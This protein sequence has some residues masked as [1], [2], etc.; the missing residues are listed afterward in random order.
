MTTAAALTTDIRV[1]SYRQALFI[2]YFLCDHG[3]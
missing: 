2:G 1:L 3:R